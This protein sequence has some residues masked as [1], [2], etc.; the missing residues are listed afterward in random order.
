[1]FI[2]SDEVLKIIL[3]NMNHPDSVCKVCKGVFEHGRLLPTNYK[4]KPGELDAFMFPKEKLCSGKC[5]R[6]W[7]SPLR[8]SLEMDSVD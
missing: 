3:E 8:K 6:I 7:N 1:M 4:C 2:N 5:H